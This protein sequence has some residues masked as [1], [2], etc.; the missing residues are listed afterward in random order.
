MYLDDKTDMIDALIFV[1]NPPASEATQRNMWPFTVVVSAGDIGE[2]YIDLYAQNSRS[3]PYQD[4]QWRWGHLLP[5]WRFTDLDGN[6]VERIKT[7]DV[8][9]S[10][11]SGNIIGVTG[12]AQFYYIDDMP[13]ISYESPV[14]IWGSLDVSSRPVEYDHHKLPIAGHANSRVIKGEPYYINGQPPIYLDITSNGISPI[15]D[16]KWINTPFRYTTVIMSDWLNSMCPNNAPIMVFDYPQE[17]ADIFA[18]ANQINRD[19]LY[20]PTSSETWSPLS[21][22]FE[23]LTDLDLHS[24]GFHIGS[25]D[26]SVTAMNTQIS[27]NVNVEYWGSYRDTPYAWISNGEFGKLQRI[28]LPYNFNGITYEHPLLPGISTFSTA[29]SGSGSW[30][31]QTS[32]VSG[33]PYWSDGSLVTDIFGGI[34]GIAVGPCLDIWTVDAELDQMYNF[35]AAG[36]MLTAIDISP[37]GSMPTSIVLDGNLDMWVTLYGA[38]ST[39][40]FDRYGNST[41]YVAVPPYSITDLFPDDG[42]D[43]DSILVRP[44]QVETDTDNNIWVS[45]EHALSS[46][47]LKYDSSGVFITSC[48]IPISSQPQGLV[49]DYVDNSIWVANTYEILVDPMSWTYAASGGSIQHFTSAGELIETYLDIPHPGFMTLD[50]HSN[51]WFTFGYSGVGVISGSDVLQYWLSAGEIVPYGNSEHIDIDNSQL[52]LNDTIKGIAVDSKNRVWALD[53]RNSTIYVINGY[54]H[55]EINVVYVTPSDTDNVAY[56][57]QALG[58]WTG[59]QWMQKYI[60]YN[61]S[62]VY[63][64]SGISN[65]F[66]INEFGDN[67][68][69]RKFNESWDATQQI[70]DYALSDHVYE[71]VNLFDTYFG[72]MIGGLTDEEDSIGRK[73]YERIAN[74]V[75]NHVDVD[76]CGI[77]QL[78]SL[79]KQLDVPMDDYSLN[80]P[81]KLKRMMDII[82][83]AHTRLWGTRCRCH[84]NFSARLPVCTVCGHNHCLNRSASQLNINTDYITGGD[85]IVF[86]PRFGLE[87]YDVLISPITAMSGLSVVSAYPISSVESISWMLSADYG[88]YKFYRYIPTFCDV[89]VEGVINWDDEYTTLSE[90]NS[91]LSSWYDKDQMVDLMLNYELR[92]GLNFYID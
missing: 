10:D 79:A 87:N 9:I 23:R 72:S 3:R 70:H 8:Q 21:A 66:D 52:P 90:N 31:I 18:A 45:Y 37:S 81:P 83:I 75:P 5:Q 86:Q 60:T 48:N 61:I 11:I 46:M 4:P 80:F 29:I 84:Q 24:G 47:V 55:S 41:G 12:T 1:N 69:I 71:N 38:T 13:S 58:D 65:E 27:A 63:N 6:V 26:S 82:S 85:K 64:I 68:K 2:H 19:I 35:S 28:S 51:L 16:I 56:S 15:A 54:D 88:D 32:A 34:L 25:V 91:S 36:D 44:V 39:V 17:S 73:S 92:R 49:I 50:S 78:Y 40:K 22:Y 20:V 42:I 67:Y 74:F 57:L 30:A 43:P 59:W 77:D 53:S 33:T 89:Q 62:D 7:D 76:T 14:I